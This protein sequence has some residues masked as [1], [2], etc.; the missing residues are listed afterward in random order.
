MRPRVAR[1]EHMHENVM[2]PIQGREELPSIVVFQQPEVSQIRRCKVV[3]GQ[4][5][6]TRVRRVD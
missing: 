5:Y 2:K 4:V 1:E 3:E 6:A